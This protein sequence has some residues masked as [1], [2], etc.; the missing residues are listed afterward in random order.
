MP[1]SLLVISRQAPWTGPN[2][3]EALDIV[4]AGGAF[5][6]PVGMLFMDDGV[7]QL[8]PEQNASSVQQ[9]DLCANLQALSLFGVDDLFACCDSLADR[10]ILPAALSASALKVLT[11]DQLSV[12]IDRYDQVIT[13]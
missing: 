9:K 2:A 5:D 3:R 4:L 12:I 8:M 11:P 1:K 6:L 7:F 13:L 10:G